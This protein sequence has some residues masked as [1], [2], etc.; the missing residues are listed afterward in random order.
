MCSSAFPLGDISLAAEAGGHEVGW[1][2]VMFYK[3]D[4]TVAWPFF[5]K[6]DERDDV[7]IWWDHEPSLD[8]TAMAYIR[9]MTESD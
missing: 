4:R 2:L 9:E 8:E 6:G 1:A 3:P 7:S 5:M